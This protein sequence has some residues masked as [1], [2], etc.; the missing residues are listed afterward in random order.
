MRYLISIV[1][2]IICGLATTIFVSSPIASWLVANQVF[3][4]PDDVA[5]MHAMI[6]LLINLVGVIVGWTVGWWVGGKLERSDN[7][8]GSATQEL[9]TGDATMSSCSRPALV[10]PRRHTREAS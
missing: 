5:S 7:D 6:F 10:C 8:A 4:S 1:A 3:E 9:E 2:A